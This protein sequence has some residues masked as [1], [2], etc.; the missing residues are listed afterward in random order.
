MIIA[1][2]ATGLSGC[3][4]T[5]TDPTGIT[6]VPA[7]LTLDIGEKQTL[8][9]TVL[10]NNAADKTVIWSSNDAT[11]V[12]V[13]ASTGEVTAIA[14]GTAVVTAT[15]INGKT[16]ACTITVNTPTVPVNG[17]KISRLIIPGDP[18]ASDEGDRTDRVAE[19][20]YDNQNRLVSVTGIYE[21]SDNVIRFAYSGNTVT[22]TG[23]AT[24]IEETVDCD[25]DG[26]CED[27]EVYIGT[28]TVVGQL[29]NSGYFT[30]ATR[31][32]VWDHDLPNDVDTQT[33]TYDANGY[34]TG[35]SFSYPGSDGESKTKH[36]TTSWTAGNLTE[37][38]ET[39]T[40]YSIAQYNTI[41]NKANLDLNWCVYEDVNFSLDGCQLFAIAGLYGQRNLNMVS[42]TTEHYNYG[43]GDNTYR[44]NYSNYQL[45]NDGYVTQWT[46]SDPDNHETTPV[47]YRVEYQ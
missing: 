23:F 39:T 34:L 32:V 7:T 8:E 26:N 10:P 38:R 12:S 9:A 27:G 25:S 36:Y 4:E 37:V 44:R 45:D 21:N 13:D 6:V 28:I 15:T 35:I 2:A 43:S 22:I 46:C 20:G 3:E 30:S 40:E 19:F 41:P 42:Q 17:K 11:K 16:A 5:A 29:N 33:L 24:I 1:V 31:T 47:V 14:A 18:N